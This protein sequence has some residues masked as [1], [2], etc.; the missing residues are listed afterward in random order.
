MEVILT[1][2]VPKLGKL[3]DVVKVKDGFGRNYLVPRKLAHVA[4][5]A[6]LRQIEMHKK[7]QQ[8]ERDLEKEA[9]AWQ[10]YHKNVRKEESNVKDK[11][12]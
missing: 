3:G 4:T 10:T 9:K 2:D 5:P 12:L 1:Q 6:T 8:A 11:N 7:K